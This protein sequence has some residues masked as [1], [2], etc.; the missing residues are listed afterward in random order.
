M[1]RGRALAGRLKSDLFGP[2]APEAASSVWYTGLVIDP[3]EFSQQLSNLYVSVHQAN[4]AARSVH[5]P[6]GAGV[7]K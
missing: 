5:A 3:A 2:P 7:S 1:E 4:A 6:V